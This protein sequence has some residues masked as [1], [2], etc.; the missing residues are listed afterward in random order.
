MR[1]RVA[2]CRHCDEPIHEMQSAIG[3]QVPR[4][5]WVHSTRAIAGTMLGDLAARTQVRWPLLWDRTQEPAAHSC[6]EP[7]GC[8]AKPQRAGWR[9]AVRRA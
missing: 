6:E 5:F 2:T 4:T 8:V 1:R 9:H 7:A 3:A